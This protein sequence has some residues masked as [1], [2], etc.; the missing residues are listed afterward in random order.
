VT[1]TFISVDK[2]QK[3]AVTPAI[4]IG[5][6]PAKGDTVQFLVQRNATAGADTKAEAV[7]FLGLEIFITLDEVNDA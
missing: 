4:T 7:Y 1:D 6:S 5:G 2:H 3:T